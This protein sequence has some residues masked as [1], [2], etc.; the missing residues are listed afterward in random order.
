MTTPPP[1]HG[2]RIYL[3]DGTIPIAEYD[4]PAVFELDTTRL[5]DGPHIFRVEATAESGFL[6]VREIPFVVRN[7]PGIAVSGLDPGQVVRGTRH[8]IVNAYAGGHVE[9][10]EPIRAETPAPIPTWAW[11]VCLLSAAWGIFYTAREWR[12]TA[13]FASTPTFAGWS[14]TSSLG[15]S[16]A[17]TGAADRGAELYRVTCA[18]CHQANGEGVPG[19]T[20]PLAR[21]PVVSGADA[22]AHAQIVLF[23]LSGRVI[24]GVHYAAAMPAWGDQLSDDEIAAIMNYERT[25]WNN[26]APLTTQSTVAAVRARHT[27]AAP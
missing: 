12:P 23:G 11:V 22:A 10:W 19:A 3:D 18:T 9:A 17:R 5:T 27:P 26:S 25:A 13:Q 1:T 7:G 15:A 8:I 16:G 20:P 4:P 24:N 14:A 21:D 6:A 2:V